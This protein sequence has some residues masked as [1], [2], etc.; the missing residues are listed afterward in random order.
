MKVAVIGAGV[1]GSGIASAIVLGGHEAIVYDIVPE[2][3]RNSE[4][5]IGSLIREMKGNSDG[6]LGEFHVESS[7]N[8][9]VK[10]ADIVLEVIIEDL[11]A[12]RE[13]YEQL[14][15]YI[16]QDVPVASN[17]STFTVEQLS[18]DLKIQDR[19]LIAHWVNP[20]YVIP[21]VEIARAPWTSEWA[22]NKI[23][24]FL[25]EL[26]K[27]PVIVPDIPGL[28]VNRFNSAVY[29]E[30]LRLVANYNIDPQTIDLVWKKHLAVI[31]SVTGVLGTMDYVGLDTIVRAASSL[32]SP[33][34]D[35]DVK[36]ASLIIDKVSRGEL[37][38]KSGL[39]FYPYSGSDRLSL[40]LSRAHSIRGVL[41]CLEDVS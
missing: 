31:F 40:E 10:G 12:K 14:T 41:K 29:R 15:T 36:A 19:I 30:A 11:N 3:L 25:K 8:E 9:A 37:G 38:V 13:L 20:P 34:Q 7:L 27:E 35:E 16:G 21:L 22:V 24:G 26:G 1:M 18:K 5:L 28:I 39:G 23:T 17:T 33:S 2:V 6:E 4:K 32:S